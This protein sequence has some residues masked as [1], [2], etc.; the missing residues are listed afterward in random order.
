MIPEQ[1]KAETVYGGDLGIVQKG[2]LPLDVLGLRLSGQTL[3]YTISG[4]E[5][6]AAWFGKSNAVWRPV[7]EFREGVGNRPISLK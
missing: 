7:P 5:L 3:G 2:G 6:A 4:K 1:K